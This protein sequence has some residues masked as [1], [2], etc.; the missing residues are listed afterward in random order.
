MSNRGSVE[1]ACENWLR[2]LDCNQRSS[3]YGPDEMSCFSTPHFGR[4]ELAVGIDSTTSP[5]RRGC[6]TLS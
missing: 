5:V 4:L 6:S 2:G 1:R 3:S